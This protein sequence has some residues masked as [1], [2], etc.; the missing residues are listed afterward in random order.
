M[1]KLPAELVEKIYNMLICM[2]CIDRDLKNEII[3]Y[4]LKRCFMDIIMVTDRQSLTCGIIEGLL[5]RCECF[6]TRGLSIEYI[7]HKW[8]TMDSCERDTHRDILMNPWMHTRSVFMDDDGTW[9]I[10]YDLK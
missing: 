5:N 3:L 8:I 1:D 6:V 10:V 7:S 2:K 9:S 4:P